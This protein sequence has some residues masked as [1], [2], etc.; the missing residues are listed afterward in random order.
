MPA[1]Q[2]PH[3]TARA[4]PDPDLR[5]QAEGQL[6]SPA[7]TALTVDRAQL[8]LDFQAQQHELHVH[9]IELSL[10][11][12]ELQRSNAELQQMRDVYRDLYDLSPV[13]Y[14]T[15]SEDGR[16][17][18]VNRAGCELL[19]AERSALLRQRFSA[20]LD[21]ASSVPFALLL[22][23]AF[24][25]TQA[26]DQPVRAE[27]TLQL[28]GGGRAEIQLDA[29][30]EA[31]REPPYLR[32]AVTDI[33][34]LKRA[35]HDIAELNAG[36]EQRVQDRT[37]RISELS[38]E[39]EAFV[40]AVTH[41]LQTPLRQFTGLAALLRRRLPEHPGAAPADGGLHSGQ[42]TQHYLREMLG[43]VDRMNALVSALSEYFQSG[44][45]LSRSMSVNLDRVLEEVRKE[46][47]PQLQGR[48]VVWHQDPLPTVFGDPLS[49]K[50]MF[51]ALL[52][53]A[54][55]FSAGQTPPEIS[56][57]AHENAHEF[58]I[59]VRDNGVGFNPRQQER[60][61]G[62]FQRLHSEREYSGLGTGLAG[63]R[64]AALRQGGRVWAEGQEGQGSCFW[65]ALPK[66]GEGL[67]P[68]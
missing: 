17:L 62:V 60:L 25:R 11:L 29:R 57:V 65:L 38:E 45:Q 68:P 15:L 2:D 24:A 63:V 67:T 9:Q 55:K 64:R 39:L 32:A 56:I 22:R 48:G 30:A 18:E 43:S 10:Q 20:Y 7:A 61:F 1:S 12:E 6:R 13:G 26:G 50:Q 46:A 53:N 66:E 28:P 41:N 44:R 31:G 23:R 59:G 33:T 42:Q 21:E 49:L 36:L 3:E 58:L 37:A 54:L 19:R 34:A 52:D 16:V 14:F 8:E 27:L 40:Q 5:T 35:Q 4:A 47:Q 51:T